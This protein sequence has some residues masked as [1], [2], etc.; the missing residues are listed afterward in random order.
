MFFFTGFDKQFHKNFQGTSRWLL[1]NYIFLQVSELNKKLDKLNL[2]GSICPCILLIACSL[3]RAV[4]LEMAESQKLDNFIICFNRFVAHPG[5][6]QKVYSDH[7]NTFKATD[8]WSKAIIKSERIQDYPSG[9]CIKWQLN[10]SWAPWWRR[11][12]LFKCMVG[13]IKHCL[14]KFVGKANLKWNKLK[15][16]LLDFENTLNNRPINYLGDN[17]QFLLL[18]IYKFIICVSLISLL[19]QSCIRLVFSFSDQGQGVSFQAP[20]PKVKILYQIWWLHWIQLKILD[21][22]RWCLWKLELV[23]WVYGLVSLLDPSGPNLVSLTWW[24]D[25]AY[26]S[27]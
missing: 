25:S 15:E 16:I 8:D 27:G 5:R 12:C 14:Y 21:R 18:S 3:S 7:V 2:K 4:H 1:L 24:L 9:S 11:R 19:S 17:I 23:L 6:P 13:L 10:L 26:D 20:E 22:M